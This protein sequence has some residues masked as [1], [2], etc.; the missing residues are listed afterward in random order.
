M[1]AT[2]YVTLALL[3]WALPALAQYSPSIMVSS[4]AAG[5][6]VATPFVLD[7]TTSLCSGQPVAATGYS[8]DNGATTFVYA[9]SIN[10]EISASLGAHILHV[11]SWG[12]A[13]AGCD[14]D[15]PVTVSAAAAPVLYTDVS[16]SQP[17]AN[18]ELVSPFT[19]I[20]SGTQCDSQPIAAMGFS[21]DDSSATTFVNGA[22]I[23]AP[24][25]SATGAH[26]LHV[27]SWGN[28][29]SGCV[30]NI[31]I[32][33]MPSPISLLPAN[34]IAVQSIQT[35]TNWQ[36][37]IDTA[38]SA[39]ASTV[40]ITNLASTPS[41]SGT[42]REFATT[43]ASL[44][45][46]RYDVSFGAD[47]SATN[48]LYDAWVYLPSPS[49]D[50]A[51]LEFDLNQVMDNGDTVIFGFQCDYWLKTWDYTANA[52]TP[53]AP[54]DV[55]VASTAACNVQS[56]TT[57]AW[58]HVQVSY[59]RDSWGNATYQSVWL[60]NVEQDLNVTVP[61][62]FALGWSPTLLTNFQVDSMNSSETTTTAYV[63]NLTI[64]R[65]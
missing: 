30:S 60:D 28:Q 65:W 7:G 14:T 6:T 9:A 47:T 63:D 41:L 20:S 56:W 23:N 26:T 59:S 29:G 54:A 31:A 33:V 27:K 42:S 32:T 50:I 44:G 22:A 58:H 11:K 1:K 46:E 48:F 15:V 43:F 52:G 34:T 3:A 37:A 40:G 16:V 55:W 61:D 12:N 8:L 19:L 18:A 62:S 5:A 35:L 4:P 57:N 25:T 13:G 10:A 51:N 17:A 45:G 24:V 38:T 53:Q 21:I 39:A 49:T 2:Y 36:A 64:Y